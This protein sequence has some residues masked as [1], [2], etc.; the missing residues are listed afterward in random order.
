[1][2]KSPAA[3]LY[4]ATG[5]NPVAVVFDG[6]V[7]RL[8]TEARLAAGHGLAL[9]ATLVARLGTLGQ[10]AMAESAPVVIAS[11]QSTV[12]VNAAQWIGSAAPTVGQK[13][14][15]A[16]IPV[17]F[18][19]DQSPLAIGVADDVDSDR[20]W[21]VGAEVNMPVANTDNPLLL[22]RN[23]NGSGKT[24]YFHLGYAGTSITNVAAVFKL[25]ANP[26]VTV[27]G[28]TVTPRNRNVGGAGA[29]VGLVTTTPTVSALG[30]KLTSLS[31]G[32]NNNSVVF[33]ED[34]S[35]AIQP[36][37]SLLLTGDPSS[38]NREAIIAV[39]W[40]EQ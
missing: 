8:A 35:I 19:S 5:T 39:S 29:A 28:T 34:F 30:N 10:K 13:L 6:A 9:D 32:Q 23:P 37:N 36:N 31:L 1:M 17:T 40:K 4:D 22:L 14:M 26:T 12:P 3:I 38:N 24:L 18:A 11:D 21:S 33:A 2:S 16:S 25:Y 20:M 7:Y 27:V 15:A